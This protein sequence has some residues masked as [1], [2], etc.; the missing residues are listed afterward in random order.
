MFKKLSSSLFLICA[1]VFSTLAQTDNK[2]FDFP[3][4]KFDFGMVKEG[5]LATH[6]F[7]FTNTGKDTI[8]LGPQNV[9]AS[10]G[11]TT[12]SYTTTPILPGQ[13][14]V[15]TAQFNSSGRPGPFIKNVM[16]YYKDDLVKM[17]TIKGIV[18][19][20]VAPVPTAD[21]IK[22]SSKIVLEKNNLN[23]G[24][25]ERGQKGLY[26]IKVTNQGK[27][28]L[29]IKDG[30]VACNCISYKL[31]KEKSSDVITYI[32]PGKS[33]RLEFTYAPTADGYNRDVITL[34]TNDVAH[35]RISLAM[36]ATVVE[37]LQPNSIIQED[38]TTTPFSK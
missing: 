20:Y 28:T 27:D 12:P 15:I 30:K 9:R 7:E 2:G 21:Q 1:I 34:V 18:D 6:T 22:T 32:L 11:C 10:C 19:N 3:V 33:A 8:V 29:F 13:K 26:S 38:N 14:G 35:E 16:V 36:D 25:V 4:D 31:Y 23:I 17:L 37:S 5:D 24:K